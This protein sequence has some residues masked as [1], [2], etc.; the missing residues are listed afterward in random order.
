M[1]SP[2]LIFVVEI[3]KLLI[4][5]QIFK[6]DPEVKPKVQLNVKLLLRSIHSF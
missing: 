5:N 3:L 1:N 6:S 2:P 4:E